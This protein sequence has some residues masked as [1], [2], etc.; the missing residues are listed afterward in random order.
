[1]EAEAA[2]GDAPVSLLAG[3]AAL[4]PGAHSRAPAVAETLAT[5]AA[6]LAESGSAAEAETLLR[7]AIEVTPRSGSARYGYAVFLQQAG[8]L[9]EALEELERAR[10][11]SPD[12]PRIHFQLGMVHFDRNERAA[13]E[14]AF[15][16]ALALDPYSSDAYLGLAYVHHTPTRYKDSIRYAQEY[17]RLRP[18]SAKGHIMLAR[19]Y[20]DLRQFARAEGEARVAVGLDRADG[21]SWHLLALAEAGAPTA[22][23]EQREEAVESFTRAVTLNPGFPVSHYEL[24]RLLLQLGRTP[25][26]VE[27]L[28]RA[29]DLWPGNGDYHWTLMQALRRAEDKEGADREAKLARHYTRYKREQARLDQRIRHA[30]K[31]VQHY[32]QLAALHLEYGQ[33][34]RA[35]TVLRAAL[36]IAPG[37]P[38]LKRLLERAGAQAGQPSAP[39]LQEPAP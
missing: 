5:A 15:R 2:T 33:A 22:S 29:V 14:A 37:S 23:A 26:A 20:L 1:L 12:D 21:A 28:K 30:P 32:E 31:Q 35:Q 36:A 19:L 17:N 8:R 4:P 13:A 34:A 18:R 16:R 6:R 39:P 9:E 24:G 25:E 11:F 10:V 3:L 27:A 38:S 7:R